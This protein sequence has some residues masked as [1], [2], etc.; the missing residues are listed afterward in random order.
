MHPLCFTYLRYKAINAVR[1][2]GHEGPIRVHGSYW[3]L[4]FI[5]ATG[6]HTTTNI[7]I[8]TYMFACMRACILLYCSTSHDTTLHYIT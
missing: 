6:S 4:A 1:P 8:H 3:K 2:Y 5:Q 7:C